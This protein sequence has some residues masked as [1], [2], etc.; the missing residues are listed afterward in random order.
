MNLHMRLVSRVHI[1]ISRLKNTAA[2]NV[3]E[4]T[5][6][7]VYVGLRHARQQ[8]K[9]LTCDSC[10]MHQWLN[11]EEHEAE[12]EGCLQVFATTGENDVDQACK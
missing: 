6:K 11:G 3:E 5:K 7:T 10:T 1:G 8:L 12:G 9:N 4:K 2:H